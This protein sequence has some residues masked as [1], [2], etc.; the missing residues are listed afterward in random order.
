M[1][2]AEEKLKKNHCPDLCVICVE[3]LRKI[4]IKNHDVKERS[5]FKEDVV[6]R[7]K[8]KILDYQMYSRIETPSSGSWITPETSDRVS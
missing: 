1:G 5:G 6:T 2:M 4:D 7:V 8:K 3:Y